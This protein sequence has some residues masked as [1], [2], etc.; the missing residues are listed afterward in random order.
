MLLCNFRAASRQNSIGEEAGPISFRLDRRASTG[1]RIQRRSTY[2]SWAL[3]RAGSAFEKRSLNIAR[4]ILFKGS[5]HV[6]MLS[7]LRRGVYFDEFEA[8]SENST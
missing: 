2:K 6:D 4:Y 3:F 5:A 8:V 1:S 7:L